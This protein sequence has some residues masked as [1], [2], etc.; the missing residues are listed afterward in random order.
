MNSLSIEAAL[1]RKDLAR[2]FLTSLDPLADRFTFQLISE[3]RSG[4]AEV[5]HCSLDELWPK[6]QQLNTSNRKIGIFVT[7]NSTD[8][9]GRKSENIVACRALFVDA[10]SEEQVKACQSAFSATGAWPNLTVH[11]SLG[12]AH[13]YWLCDDIPPEKFTAIQSA[14]IAKLKTDGSVKDLP[15][16]M[17][18]PGTLHLKAVPRVVSLDVGKGTRRWKLQDLMAALG[19]EV[20][21][22]S[23]A[24]ADGFPAPRSDLLAIFG[25][26]KVDNS[27]LSG[28]LACNLDDIISA[29]NMLPPAEISSEAD[30]VRVARALAHEARQQPEHA[31]KIYE[32][33]DRLSVQADNYN[34]A[35][36]RKRWDRY[37]SEAFR[38][39]RP[40]TIAT[41]FSAAQKFG[42]TL[43]TCLNR[44][45]NQSAEELPPV[46]LELPPHR[47]WLYGVDLVRGEITLLASP[48]GIGKSSLAIG[49]TVSTASGQ[50][51]LGERIYGRGLRA[52]YINA[53]DS[54][55]EMK[56]RIIAFCARHG[57]ASSALSGFQ[58]LGSD[59]SE[60]QSLSFLRSEKGLST[61]DSVGIGNLEKLLKA[62]R[63][64]LVVLDPLV[65][66]CGGG[67]MN[68]NAA[69]SLVMRAI[70]RA[71]DKFRCSFL[72]L[73][74]T[75]KGGDLSSAEA[76]G[77]A[78]AIVNLSRRA[79]MLSPMTSEEATK[80]G[81]LPSERG[82]HFRCTA[83]K[84]NLV[85]SSAI[86]PWFKLSSVT[87]QNQQ[88]PLY[89][90][91]DG[92][93]AVERLSLPIGS[94]SNNQQLLIQKAIL[95]TIQK[96]AIVDGQKVPFSP[97]AAGSQNQRNLM[98]A[99]IAAAKLST[100]PQQWLDNDI[101]AVV[102][103]AIEELKS[104]GWVTTETITSGPAR[105]RKGLKANWPLTPWAEP[106]QEPPV[107]GQC[108]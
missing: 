82:A 61:L 32:Q 34:G 54:S 77:G 95:E 40:I 5:L 8:F 23:G 10:D 63:P 105:R 17:R 2:K 59:N 102:K 27:E 72:V 7:I 48:G 35:E 19:L 11:T 100:Y 53:E 49:I 36:N 29:L 56:R 88:P 97:S 1:H 71:A 66:L 58:L 43:G 108:Q 79:L 64:D 90:T 38:H 12:R 68:D 94:N 33:F 96:G 75:R 39:E 60:T 14:L 51:L 20:E 6:V 16:V 83:S 62:N 26:S 24:Y 89:P 47:E 103:R 99:S 67:N 107:N 86:V 85:A 80:F 57:V 70:K 73:H 74:H 46:S 31:N 4:V 50:S 9:M 22:Q 52:L 37:V 13:Y 18:V 101:R 84:S 93:Q 81:V 55:V 106:V 87:L 42:W 21:A 92:V 78:S 69:M 44:A 104:K 15:R 28:G 76:I 30:W 65:A 3:D 98:E 91:G 25:I 41:L 45:E